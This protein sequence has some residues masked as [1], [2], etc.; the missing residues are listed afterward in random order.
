MSPE[1]NSDQNEHKIITGIPEGLG[2]ESDRD[3]EEQQPL[4]EMPKHLRVESAVARQ[5]IGNVARVGEIVTLA[6]G[7]FQGDPRRVPG[8]PSNPLYK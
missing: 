7:A 6:P 4:I 8:H 3:V 2:L 5:A 1:S